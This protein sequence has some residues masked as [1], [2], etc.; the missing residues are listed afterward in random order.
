M[1]VKVKKARI[2]VLEEHRDELIKSLQKAS[3]LMIIPNHSENV[4][5][6]FEIALLQRANKALSDIGR[7][8]KKKSLFQY[9]EVTYERFMM[10]DHAQI[11]LLEQ[12]EKD[13]ESLA[14][15]KSHIKKTDELLDK[16]LPFRT[17]D[18]KVSSL[19]ASNYVRFHA[20]H[21]SESN[22]EMIKHYLDS[23]E[24][25][26]QTL[27][28]S[29]YGPALFFASFLEEDKA[30]GEDIAKYA[31]SEIDLPEID[32]SMS[33]YVAQLESDLA[34]SKNE[35]IE[36]QTNLK[37]LSKSKDQIELL[38]DRLQAQI[39]RKSVVFGK[40]ERSFYLDGWV[41]EDQV[42][43]LES[44]ISSTTSEYDLE[45][46]DP[47]DAELPPTALKNNKFIAH[48]ES[49]TNMF[50]IPNHSEIDPNP[51]M[52]VWYW[53]IFGIMMG[54][55]GYG[56]IMLILFGL[57]IK[58]LKPKGTLK[59]L[60]SVFFFSGITSLI[61]GVLFGSFFGADFDLGALIGSLFGLQW[62]SVLLNPVA[63]PLVMLGF[64]LILGVLH[65]INGLGLKIALL[66]KRKDYLG[67]IADGLSW[68]LV[69]VGLLFVGAQMLIW[70]SL[71]YLN[72]IGLSLAGAG[73]LILLSLAGRK[74]KNIFGK[75]FGGLGAIY[76]ST[77]Y[78]SDILSYSRILALSLSTAVIAWTM[79]LLAGMLQQSIVGFIFSIL[80]YLVGHL[81]NFAM[82][83]LSAY[84]H[85]GRLQYI[86]FF[87]KFYEGGGYLFEPFAIRLK[88]INEIS[89][90]REERR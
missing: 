18:M 40:T 10:E 65:I 84:V 59:Q 22:L 50:S 6:T 36:M 39:D 4:D 17:I 72:Y 9:H 26:Y 60:I 20:G 43:Q 3:L 38:C 78:V 47:T 48:F 69:L 13:V 70:T 56:M 12:I 63:N 83:M 54:D 53:L 75:I 24:I 37:E 89:D 1:I 62:T 49:I 67:A 66:I 32:L 33:E 52:A 16:Y 21:V 42:E 27:S 7:Y 68:I 80:V 64:S 8:G 23:K 88:Q 15:A 74:S 87:G 71:M 30:I 41:R 57:G 77:G 28:A 76:K 81:F 46:S 85:D 19:K 2:F 61:A 73:A 14:S 90:L 44:T 82:G 45:L 31:F 58:L 79:N 29:D 34:A 35:V 11:A 55:I 86:E 5:V 51:F 25:P